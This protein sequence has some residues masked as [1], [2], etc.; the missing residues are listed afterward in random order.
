[1][2]FVKPCCASKKP[3]S[4][5]LISDQKSLPMRQNRSLPFWACFCLRLGRFAWFQGQGHVCHEAPEHSEVPVHGT[6]LAILVTRQLEGA[7]LGL[8][9]ELSS[10]GHHRLSIISANPVRSGGWRLRRMCAHTRHAVPLCLCV[11][12]GKGCLSPLRRAGSGTL[13]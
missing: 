9:E 7:R 10:I 1:M 2:C 5:N 4:S 8:L 13:F 11:W 12:K 3:Q 6:E